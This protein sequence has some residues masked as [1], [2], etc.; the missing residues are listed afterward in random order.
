MRLVELM[1]VT[2]K[3]SPTSSS[4]SS[5]GSSKEETVINVDNQ[6]QSAADILFD[7][8]YLPPGRPRAQQIPRPTGLDSLPSSRPPL[9][10][11]ASHLLPSVR[12]SDV[13]MGWTPTAPEMDTT[14][15]MLQRQFSWEHDPDPDSMSDP[16]KTPT[17][18]PIRGKTA[19]SQQFASFYQTNTTAEPVP[20][21]RVEHL[22]DEELPTT[23]KSQ[24]PPQAE[25]VQN[26]RGSQVVRKVNSGFEILRP[27]TLDQQQ[28]QQQRQ[29][30]RS[31]DVA[32]SQWDE[33]AGQKRHSRK[34][35]RK[36]A[37]SGRSSIFKEQI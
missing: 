9:S 13:G 34:L 24:D 28:Q 31:I 19:D 15:H 3:T 1:L 21:C 2:D 33:E 8:A 36:R 22:G 35:R 23:S 7:P 4:K 18:S 37:S 32:D 6:R 14:P 29:Q 17:G 5:N 25:S 27:G 11:E 10:S 26:Q 20:E 12:L 16:F 30:R